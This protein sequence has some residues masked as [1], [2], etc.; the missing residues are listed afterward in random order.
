MKKKPENVSYFVSINNPDALKRNLLEASKTMVQGLAQYERFKAVRQEKQEAIRKLR[1]DLKQT[2][3][4]IS[5]LKNLLPQ[6]DVKPAPAPKI[7]RQAKVSGPKE[8]E[9]RRAPRKEIS[10]LEKL[11]AEL[12]DIEN[13]L[14]TMK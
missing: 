11:E 8:A 7:A 5:R 12:D 4:L 2:A 14:G 3:A 1:L 13:K 10:E 6:V 9:P